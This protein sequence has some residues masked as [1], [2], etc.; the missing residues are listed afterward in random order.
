M[1]SREFRGIELP[2]SHT[3]AISAGT[4]MAAPAGETGA[5][6]GRVWWLADLCDGKII[7]AEAVAAGVEHRYLRAQRKPHGVLT[8]KPVNL[9]VTNPLFPT[10]TGGSAVFKKVVFAIFSPVKIM[11]TL[12]ELCPPIVQVSGLQTCELD[13]TDKT[14]PCVPSS[15]DPTSTVLC[16]C[17]T[18]HCFSVST[19]RS[20]P[21]NHGPSLSVVS[22]CGRQK[23][24]TAFSSAAKWI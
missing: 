15:I 13:S 12:V 9:R 23:T 21:G 11:A 22:Q 3:I 18:G 17:L 6:R 20:R 19:G 2:C 5:W 16:F 4:P 8:L 24:L 14:S 10:C 1:R 7:R